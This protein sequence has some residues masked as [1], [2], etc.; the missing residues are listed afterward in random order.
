MCLKCGY[1][2]Y[3]NPSNP[4]PIE[5]YFPDNDIRLIRPSK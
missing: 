4:F 5:K 3:K 1:D 2:G